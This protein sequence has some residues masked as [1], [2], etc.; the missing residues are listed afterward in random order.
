MDGDVVLLFAV[1]AAD[2]G[3]AVFA[4]LRGGLH[5]DLREVLVCAVPV[6][7][8]EGVH[9][10]KGVF[11]EGGNAVL[12]RL[13]RAVEFFELGNGG[14]YLGSGGFG[15]ALCLGGGLL[16]RG[17]CRFGVGVGGFGGG[18]LGRGGFLFFR[19]RRCFV[20]AFFVGADG[21]EVVEQGGERFQCRCAGAFGDVE[22]LFF[23]FADFYFFF[24]NRFAFPDQL[25]HMSARLTYCAAVGAVQHFALQC[26]N[27]FALGAGYFDFAHNDF[28]VA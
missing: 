24:G 28:S 1:C 22:F 2:G 11:F 26:G 10:G 23:F 5:G 25:E 3:A 15:G 12:Q 27:V 20:F 19:L 6:Q 18:G 9:F 14:L 4:A 8:G 21:I 7:Q 13:L 17:V 16:F